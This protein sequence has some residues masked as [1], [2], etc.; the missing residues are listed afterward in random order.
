M[1]DT[2]TT[3]LEPEA[4]ALVAAG[5]MANAMLAT[6]ASCTNPTQACGRW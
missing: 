6:A 1:Q 2:K 5:G 4:I 3:A